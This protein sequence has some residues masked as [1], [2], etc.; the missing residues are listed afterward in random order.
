MDNFENNIDNL[1][2]SFLDGDD[3]SFSVLYNQQS[4]KLL[5]YGYKLCH[6]H[7]L[8]HDSLQEVFIDLFL[9]RDKKTLTVEN[10]KSYL[11]ICFRNSIIKKIANGRKF[12]KLSIRKEKIDVKFNTEYSYQ[13]NLINEEI[14][15]EISQQLSK[16]I[17][18]LPSKQKEI[19]YLKFEQGMEYAEI[20]DIMKISVES[21]RKLMYRTL[22][23]LRKTLDTK[24]FHALILIF[25]KK[26]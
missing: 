16:A 2:K 26:S 12:E 23:A 19:I 25:S 24:L 7:E 13:T 4:K 17:N 9:K 18:A 22:L 20:A 3:K 14:S 1:W 10:L 11:F 15:K 5:E 21:V 8:V 6:D